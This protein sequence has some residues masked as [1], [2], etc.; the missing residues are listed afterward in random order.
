M[1][2]RQG[3]VKGDWKVRVVSDQMKDSDICLNE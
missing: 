3:G 2:N 1:R